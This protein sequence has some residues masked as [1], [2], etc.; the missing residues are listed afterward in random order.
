MPALSRFGLR[1]TGKSGI[2]ALMDDLGSA[3]RAN[4]DMIMMGGGT[5]ARIPAAEQL[6]RRHLQEIVADPER[7]FSLLGRYQEPQGDPDVRARVAHL[8]RNEYGW[9]LSA[10]NVA[11]TNGG[12]SAF[13][14]L[15]NMLAGDCEARRRV[16]QFPFVPEYL[17]YADVGLGDDFFRATRPLIETLPD[18]FFK[19]HVDFAGL[20]IDADVGALCV[21]RPT[22]PSG[23]VLG[24]DELKKMDGLARAK[25]VPFIIDAA[26]G[27]P[28]P[29]IEFGAAEAYWSDN[30]ILM[31]SVSKL[32]LPGLRGGLLVAREEV[33]QAF[34]S[35]NTIL[36]LASGNAG[37]ALLDSLLRTRELL[38]L[39]RDTIQPWYRERLAIAVDCLRAELGDLPYALHRPEGAFF[40]WLWLRDLPGGSLRLYQALKDAGVLVIPGDTCFFGLD[41]PWEHAQQCVRI[42][43]ALD[44][45]Q[46]RAAARIIG[47]VARSLYA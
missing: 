25:D 31:L 38:P 6:F 30:V 32:G 3:L 35:A 43:Y 33:V 18:N 12:Q 29:A 10:A 1:Y 40:L 27:A 16:I 8:L 4:P 41:A 15:A 44:A 34:A 19:Y 37:P 5:P 45:S 36:N 24:V 7:A 39:C 9:Q 23:N 42:S 2:V 13:A 21:S 26:Y 22:N 28:F 20:R 14:I 46:L 11:I 47:R 17:G